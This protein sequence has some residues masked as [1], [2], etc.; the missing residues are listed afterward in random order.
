MRNAGPG[1]RPRYR[2]PIEDD[3][4]TFVG[5]NSIG[6][7]QQSDRGVDLPAGIEG[8]VT[9]SQVNW[10][11]HTASCGC[12]SCADS[13][14]VQLKPRRRDSPPSDGPSSYCHRPMVARAPSSPPVLRDGGQC[15]S[16]RHPRAPSALERRRGRGSVSVG[17]HMSE[18]SHVFCRGCMPR[19]VDRWGPPRSGPPS[20][21][22]LMVTWLT[23]ISP[24]HGAG[25]NL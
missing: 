3:D 6:C 5:R 21:P 23:N 4:G 1:L 7:R 10:A 24:I 22:K 13:H 2:A 25:L 9:S 12:P 11:G 14:K 19:Y 8:T 16:L 20:T 15:W 18:L 17:T